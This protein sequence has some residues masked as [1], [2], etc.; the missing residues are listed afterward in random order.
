LSFG[1]VTG[2]GELFDVGD[3]D[4]IAGINVRGVDGLV[5]ATQAT[6]NFGSEAA[7]HLVCGVYHKP[8][9]LHLMWLGGKRFHVCAVLKNWAQ[10]GERRGF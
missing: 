3:D 10:I 7:E 8:L 9:A 1:L 2:N 4:E 6:S 5:L